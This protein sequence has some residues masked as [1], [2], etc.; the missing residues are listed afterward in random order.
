MSTPTSP[1]IYSTDMG[2][3]GQPPSSPL[4]QEHGV[5]HRPA[6]WRA[7]SSSPLHQHRNPQVASCNQLLIKETWRVWMFPSRC[8]IPIPNAPSCTTV[9]SRLVS[10]TDTVDSFLLLCMRRCA[11]KRH[12]HHPLWGSLRDARQTSRH[13]D[14]AGD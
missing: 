5:L 2:Y 4:Q 7:S 3:G 10:P 9:L 8:P 11:K 6:E 12:T 13:D 1:F 14:D